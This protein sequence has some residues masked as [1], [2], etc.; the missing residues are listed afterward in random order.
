MAI[1]DLT[2][3][4]WFGNDT[5]SITSATYNVSFTSD[6][7]NDFVRFVLTSSRI[8]RR[9]GLDYVSYSAGMYTA[10]ESGWKNQNARTVVFTGGADATNSTLIAWL[11]ANGT[12]TNLHPK[13]SVEAEYNNTTIVEFE[14]APPVSVLYNGQT[15]KELN[16]GDSVTLVCGGKMMNYNVSIGGKTLMCSGK[17]MASDVVVTARKKLDYKTWLFNETIPSSATLAK[18]TVSFTSNSKK[19]STIEGK[20]VSG[21]GFQVRYTIGTSE[22]NVYRSINGGWQNDA[23]KTVVFDDEPTGTLRTWLEANATPI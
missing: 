16:E 6:L 23:Y 2:G 9:N 7:G 22:T 13:A 17:L 15:L 18:T 11:E 3:Y 1:T 4:Q 12:L 14:A 5:L 8:P 10:Y 20:Y 19:C 21:A